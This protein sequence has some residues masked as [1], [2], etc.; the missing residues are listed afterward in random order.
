[1]MWVA[2]WTALAVPTLVVLLHVDAPYGRHARRGWGPAVPARIAWMVMEAPAALG[3][4][5]LYLAARPAGVVPAALLALWLAH[6][7]NRAVVQPLRAR[8]GT[9]MP[10]SVMA[11]GFAFNCVNVAIQGSA[12]FAPGAYA[13]AWL[14]DPRFGVGLATFV[15]GYATNAH[16]D[17][18]LRR[19]RAGG[20][21]IPR[22]GLYRWVSCP[23]YLGEIV[24]W[25]GWA[26]ATWS[27]AG[28]SF[29]VWTIANLAPRALANHRWLRERFPD[30]PRERRALVPWLV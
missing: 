21:Q 24:E 2:A 20:Y 27:L 25:I 5:A 28:A 4:P 29:A 26:I 3:L 19:L 13:D 11:M 22:G 10:A 7:V 30:Y 23:N 14:A 15:A 16:A 17:A 1:M 18:V 12:A 6:Y 8:G 9:A